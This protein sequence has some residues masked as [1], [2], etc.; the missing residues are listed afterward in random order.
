MVS[1]PALL[2]FHWSLTVYVVPLATP[3]EPC[4]KAAFGD[5]VPPNPPDSFQVS[6]CPAEVGNPA[7]VTAMPMSWLKPALAV[8]RSALPPRIAKPVVPGVK[9]M[10]RPELMSTQVDPLLPVSLGCV[11]MHFEVLVVV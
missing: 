11:V 10:L 9:A 3:N 6:G 7:P 1:V 2:A 5:R 8:K 4:T